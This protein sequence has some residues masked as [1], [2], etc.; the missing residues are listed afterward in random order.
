MGAEDLFRGGETGNFAED[1]RSPPGEMI[2]GGV[3]EYVVRYAVGGLV[4]E[5]VTFLDIARQNREP[6]KAL[7]CGPLFCGILITVMRNVNESDFRIL[8]DVPVVSLHQ[9]WS[10]GAA[11]GS[12]RG[13]IVKNVILGCLVEFG[14][15]V[16]LSIKAVQF[17]FNDLSSYDGF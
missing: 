10:R 17:G 6:G 16:A 8:C 3:E 1:C 11:G 12:P 13:G 4:F 2:S 15:F 7:L 14:L 5:K 9:L